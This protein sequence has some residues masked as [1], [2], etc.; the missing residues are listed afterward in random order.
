[1]IIMPASSRRVGT[2]M[3][4]RRRTG[5]PS[6]TR[7]AR[8]NRSPAITNGGIDLTAIRIPRDVHPHMM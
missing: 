6:I 8:P 3:R 5:L 2:G 7:P 1:M 4:P